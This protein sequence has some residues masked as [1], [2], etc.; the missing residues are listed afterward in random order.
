MWKYHE[1]LPKSPTCEPKNRASTHAGELSPGHVA[2][3]PQSV[4]ET[5]SCEAE[6]QTRRDLRN[7][8]VQQKEG[9]RRERERKRVSL[10]HLSMLVMTTNSLFFF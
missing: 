1:I 10:E 5:P 9:V 3:Q 8:S 2:R 4:S 6:S 7:S